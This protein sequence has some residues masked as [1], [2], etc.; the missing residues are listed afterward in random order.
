[1]TRIEQ[2][3]S[4]AAEPRT[5][6]LSEWGVLKLSAVKNGR[7]DATAAK[8]LPDHLQP[9]PSLEIQP[10]D[11]LITRANT[12]QYVGD[13]CFVEA[14]RPKL[15][16]SDLIYRLRVRHD[17]VDGRFLAMFLT[18][19]L[20]RAQVE[21]DARGTSSSMVKISQEHIKSWLIP[22][23]PR[24]EQTEIMREITPALESVREAIAASGSLVELL[25]ERRSALI[26]AAVTGQIDASTWTPPDDWLAPEAA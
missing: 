2:G 5:P 12:P 6:N 13:A 10:G 18:H 26:T 21:P 22:V 14:T 3:W 19:P 11:F 20:G 17:L 8:A 9:Q 16:L 23:P 1:M 4:P 15:M 25:T 7:F 24:D